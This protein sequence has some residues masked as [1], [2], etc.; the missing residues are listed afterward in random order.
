MIARTGVDWET[1]CGDVRCDTNPIVSDYLGK[2]YRKV[3]NMY[4]SSGGCFVM[5]GS[6]KAPG[7]KI[8]VWESISKKWIPESVSVLKYYAI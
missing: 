5:F 8:P 4:D 7:N 6:A 2:R 3:K 1:V